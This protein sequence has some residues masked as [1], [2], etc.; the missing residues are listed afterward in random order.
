[1]KRTLSIGPWFCTF[2]KVIT[3]LKQLDMREVP[4][5][6]HEIISNNWHFCA[7]GYIQWI[8]AIN[9]SCRLIHSV[10][11]FTSLV[12]YDLSWELMTSFFPWNVFVS[13]WSTFLILL[14]QDFIALSHWLL[15]I[16]LFQ[17]S[18]GNFYIRAEHPRYISDHASMKEQ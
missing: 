7:D 16:A 4:V 13:T 17:E 12:I 15:F 8:H 2:F 14:R 10:F 3:I 9:T 11:R 6:W 18:C 1:M 5:N